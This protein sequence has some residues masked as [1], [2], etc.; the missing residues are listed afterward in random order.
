M[1][2]A[3]FLYLII[4]LAA[5][6]LLGIVAWQTWLLLD[7]LRAVTVEWLWEVFQTHTWRERGKAAKAAR[8]A[9]AAARWTE[10]DGTERRYDF[11]LE[12]VTTFHVERQRVGVSVPRERAWQ[13][14]LI[15]ACWWGD[16]VGWTEAAWRENGVVYRPESGE[17]D[18]VGRRAIVAA[19]DRTGVTACPAL[20]RTWAA[21]MTLERATDVLSAIPL[22]S[23]PEGGPP[24][25]RIPSES[26]KVRESE[27]V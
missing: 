4:F 15:K 17:F 26:T 18:D 23:L 2:D 10:P 25:V 12:R 5:A 20:K 22:L 3:P 14:A 9:E 19:L 24:T 21:G 1:P 7:A 8:E 6:V 27:R 11:D 16:R 13:I